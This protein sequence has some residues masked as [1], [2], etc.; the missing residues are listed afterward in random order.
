[1]LCTCF[2]WNFS[3]YNIFL[4]IWQSY[5]PTSINLL[6]ERDPLMMQRQG[7]RSTLT[8]DFDCAYE[9]FK[10]FYIY[11]WL[12]VCYGIV[13]KLVHLQ[14]FFFLNVKVDRLCFF[15]IFCKHRDKTVWLLWNVV[16]LT[17]WIEIGGIVYIWI[18]IHQG[19]T[20]V[21]VI[22][23]RWSDFGMNYD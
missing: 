12:H 9:T 22:Y 17:S 2:V 7:K 6:Y 14:A 1:M 11:C 10:M 20:I 13:F 3:Y 8:Y 18:Y 23:I 16:L 5:F 4:F 19:S 15:I 21:E